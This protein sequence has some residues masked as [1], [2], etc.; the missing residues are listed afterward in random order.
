MENEQ[1]YTYFSEK[2]TLCPMFKIELTFCSAFFLVSASIQV[3]SSKVSIKTPRISAI[4]SST[5]E[6]KHQYVTD[7][8]KLFCYFSTVMA[9]WLICG[10]LSPSCFSCT[11]W[12]CVLLVDHAQALELKLRSAFSLGMGTSSQSNDGSG[13][14]ESVICPSAARWASGGIIFIYVNHKKWC[15]SSFNGRR[16]FVLG[17]FSEIFCVS[18]GREKELIVPVPHFGGMW[19]G[20][21]A[22]D[23]QCLGSGRGCSLVMYGPRLAW[24]HAFGS[25]PADG[26]DGH[27]DSSCPHV[28][29]HGL[30]VFH[31]TSQCACL[32]GSKPAQN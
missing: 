20:S 2:H 8:W 31:I 6:Q 24:L 12:L 11:G 17:M 27:T 19:S 13:Y 14:K 29:T 16:I 30:F 28:C 3:R 22:E 10:L 15:I 5:L 23:K 25:G 18:E 9:Y 26:A 1:L 32:N 4:I 7:P 21:S